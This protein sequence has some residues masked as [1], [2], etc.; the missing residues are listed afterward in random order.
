MC[1]FHQ[2]NLTRLLRS[3]EMSMTWTI[4]NAPQS[5]DPDEGEDEE[6]LRSM[7]M[8]VTAHHVMD[9]AGF[10]GIGWRARFM[11]GADI[12][13]CRVNPSE[14]GAFPRPFPDSCDVRQAAPEMFLCCVAT[15]VNV[16]PTCREPNDPGFYELNVLS[17]CLSTSEASVTLRTAVC[18]DDDEEKNGCFEL[19]SNIDGTIDVIAAFNPSAQNTP[20]GFQRRTSSVVDLK[21][22]ILTAPESGVAD[23]GLIAYHAVTMMVF[24][25]FLAPMGIYIARYMKTKTWRLIAHISIMGAVGGLMLPILIGVEFAVGAT[26]KRQE[27]AVIGLGLAFVILPMFLAGRI[28]Y[29]KLQGHK[30]GRRTA[31]VAFGFH[32]FSDYI[33]WPYLALVIVIF[34][35]AEM[36]KIRL[37]GVFHTKK[38]KGVEA[39]HSLWDD[40]EDQYDEMTMEKFLELTR[41]GS[42]LCIVDGRVLDISGFMDHHPGGRD[43]LVTCPG[44][45]ITEEVAGLQDIEGFKHVHSYFALQKM[46]TLI[47]AVLTDQGVD[48]SHPALSH[49]LVAGHGN[50]TMDTENPTSSIGR[51]WKPVFH[52]GRILD[53]RFISPFSEISESNKPVVMLR[54]AVKSM[55]TPNGEGER[56][57]LPSSCFKFRVVNP[58]GSTFEAY[59][60]PVRLMGTSEGQMMP[61]DDEETFD[62]I[63]S[64]RPGGQ[65][66]KASL[67]WK[68]GKALAIQG[69]TVNPDVLNSITS[70][71]RNTIV[72]LFASGTGIAPMLQLI[73]FYCAPSRVESAPHIFLVWVLKGPEHDY[74]EWIGLDK[75]VNRMRGKFRWITV[76]SSSRRKAK[77]SS[78][79]M[80]LS[81]EPK[82][83]KKSSTNRGSLFF[84]RSFE[85]N[86]GRK[87]NITSSV[88]RPSTVGQF[89]IFKGNRGRLI[90]SIRHQDPNVFASRVSAR[91]RDSTI[92]TPLSHADFWLVANKAVSVQL[93]Q[94]L[95]EN[96][97]TSIQSY[98]SSEESDASSYFQSSKEDNANTN[99]KGDETDVDGRYVDLPGRYKSEGVTDRPKGDTDE[100]NDR[101]VALAKDVTR[102]FKDSINEPNPRRADMLFYVCGSP[103][104]DDDI[105]VWIG[106][107]GF[108][109]DQIVNFYASNHVSL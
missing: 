95:V 25:M 102:A 50:K 12:W 109:N 68:V 82:K 101:D 47:I 104:F 74:S 29:S 89:R 17:W 9:G 16:V 97:L 66:S 8:T 106:A 24:W 103:K 75:K 48:K 42:A 96:L 33:Y 90:D 51:H 27:H 6:T 67:E 76:Y 34:L 81:E 88:Y 26:R 7:E 73:D 72:T 15:G 40:A 2:S 46:K 13:F 63:I 22:G 49:Q 10:L 78:K 108:A 65:I 98:C 18:N 84:S 99:S 80:V 92:S 59:Y 37:N 61:K 39:G 70:I 4:E 36:R 71:N 79:S 100:E 43:V 58:Y 54:L 38:L 35:V 1:R 14:F 91:R 20:H 53:V 44:S 45:D 77:V 32:K 64:L 52:R 21:A 62:F 30:V 19:A 41:L 94:D 93:N 5:N 60:T 105:R 69:P 31:L 3:G 86:G 55:C 107:N 28:R 83:E 23:T 85:Q 56:A 87:E 11:F 57:L